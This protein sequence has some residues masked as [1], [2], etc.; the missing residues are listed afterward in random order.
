[1]GEIFQQL[2]APD[3]DLWASIGLTLVYPVAAVAVALWPALRLAYALTGDPAAPWPRLRQGVYAVVRGGIAIPGITIGLILVTLLSRSG[4]LG[5]LDL[6]FHPAA[7]LAVQALLAFPLLTA[8]FAQT[9]GALPVE[10]GEL[11]VSSGA[12]AGQLRQSLIRQARPGLVSL[13]G[14]AWLRV[15]GETGAAALAGGN[16]A[17]LTRILPTAM[18]QGV[19]QGDFPRA[20][21]LGLLL[22]FVGTLGTALLRE[23][24]TR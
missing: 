7:L 2:A 15:L 19:H 23:G 20:L 9:L 24:R 16:V 6:L 13:A 21:G 22:L 10:Y 4:P 18:A 8:Y 3:A 11:A 1:M 12:T 5:F 14:L 17:G